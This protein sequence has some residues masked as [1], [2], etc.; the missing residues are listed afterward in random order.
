[1]ELCTM[2]CQEQKLVMQNRKVVSND[3]CGAE[4]KVTKGNGKNQ[5]YDIVKKCLSCG[6]SSSSG[7]EKWL[8]A[9]CEHCGCELDGSAKK[10]TCSVCVNKG[11][12]SVAPLSIELPPKKGGSK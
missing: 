4:L 8:T 11:L 6:Y 9:H 12:V 3:P 5:Y 7:N 10:R 1:M 2:K